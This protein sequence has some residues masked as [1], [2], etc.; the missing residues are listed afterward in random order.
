MRFHLKNPGGLLKQLNQKTRSV[1]LLGGNLTICEEIKNVCAAKKVLL[2]SVSTVA[3][4]YDTRR[5][6][7][8][9]KRRN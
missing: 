6:K 7:L 8:K 4:A 3:D 1:K 5:N 9:E 2:E